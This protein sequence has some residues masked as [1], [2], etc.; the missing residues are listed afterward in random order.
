MF[1]TKKSILKIVALAAFIFLV[2]CF[3][4]CMMFLLEKMDIYIPFLG[5]LGLFTFGLCI[6]SVMCGW[7]AEGEGDLIYQGINLVHKELRPADYISQYISVKNDDNLIIAKPSFKVL[8]QVLLAYDLLDDREMAL[9]T[10]EE[11][12]TIVGKRKK[13]CAYILKA[14]LLYSYGRVDKAEELFELVK[15]M[16]LNA[17]S[18]VA[19]D[20]LLKGDRAMAI[21]D[22]KVAEAYHQKTLERKFPPAD[23][24]EK[25]VSYYSLGEIYEK[26]QE[27]EKAI[28]HYQYCV[29]NGG[30]TAIRKNAA[31]KLEGLKKDQTAA[32]EE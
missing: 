31:K 18:N 14:A 29:V 3:C 21:G 15:K 9:A 32:I 20:V 24:V 2:S 4:F 25:L 5:D 28:M 10:V 23:N 27:N 22:Y 6:F 16:K 1:L 12:I 19:M 30:E 13:A 11:M 8:Q 26:L 17:M 7:E